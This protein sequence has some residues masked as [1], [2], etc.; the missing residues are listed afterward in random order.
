MSAGLKRAGS[1][2]ILAAA[3]YCAGCDSAQSQAD[4]QVRSNLDDAQ[5]M[6]RTEDTSDNARA[7]LTEAA[8]NAD[9]SDVAKAHAKAAQAQLELD[10]AIALSW[11]IDT[12]EIQ[13]SRAG[14]G[15][16][17]LA[18]QIRSSNSARAGYQK[19][20][21]KPL[22]DA[23]TAKIAEAR[24]GPDKPAWFA[25]ETSAVPTLAAVTA[26]VTELEG[27]LTKRKSEIEASTSRRTQ[28][29]D[30]AD[31]AAVQANALKGQESL[32]AFKRASESR[33][34]AGDVS[35]QI[36]GIQNQVT[37]LERRLAVAKG[38]QA[39]VAEVIKQLEEQIVAVDQ[40]WKT[41]D[42]QAGA[43][44]ALSARILGTPGAGEPA[45]GTLGST[46]SENAA[47]VA[48]LAK[49]IAEIR[50]QAVAAAT[51]ASES[52]NAAYQAANTAK[53][54]LD[55]R[56]AAKPESPEAAAW[57]ALGASLNPLQYK[58]LQSSALRV[59]GELHASEA[60]SA[61]GRI[62]LKN[63]VQ[64]ALEGTGL[65]LPAPLNVSEL[66]T[67]KQTA[68]T[69]ANKAYQES[70]ELLSTLVDGGGSAELKAMAHLNRSLS[71]YGWTQVARQEGNEAN[72]TKYLNESK[73]SRDLAF[74]NDAKL[75]PMPAE[76]GPPPKKP[77]P[78]APATEP[79]TTD[80]PAATDTPATT[81]TPATP[82]DGTQPPA[83]TA[84]PAPTPTPA[85]V[86]TPIDTPIDTPQPPAQ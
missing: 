80:T 44:Q 76:L 29:I 61:E 63:T 84:A 22:K 14:W 79:A 27:E 46:I 28:L 5:L 51:A 62:D 19:F 86:D 42:S 50:S 25:H 34:Q 4:K 13:L 67:A 40:A 60:A 68:L 6:L 55:S 41:Y 65:S 9:A 31:A 57:K 38:Q 15:I 30:Q 23:I 39:T 12:L 82:A 2:A 69:A 45:A 17:E 48:R 77:E 47:E 49:E 32:E 56:A 64:A 20:D 78:E 26:Q 37:R 35:V 70:E 36:D 33:K 3:M 81:E 7:K 21:P 8:N 11:K 52:F 10:T 72:A 53:G 54:E 24:G 18:Q 73:S 75:P 83:P 1:T 66:S 58:L 74:L 59:L 43:H 85:P 71:Y 16:I